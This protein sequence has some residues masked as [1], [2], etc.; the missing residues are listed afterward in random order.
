MILVGNNIVK[1]V[2]N[3]FRMSNICLLIPQIKRTNIFGRSLLEEQDGKT[4]TQLSLFRTQTIFKYFLNHR[5][6]QMNNSHFSKHFFRIFKIL[7]RTMANT[8]I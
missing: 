3:M 7:I 8:K 5:S 2:H 6:A 1:L 4:E